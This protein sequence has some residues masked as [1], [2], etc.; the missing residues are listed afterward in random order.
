M[1][2]DETTKAIIASGSGLAA[3]G[4]SWK[5]LPAACRKLRAAIAAK[6]SVG[7]VKGLQKLQTVYSC[8]ERTEDYGSNR[9][10]IFGGHN[11]GGL[12]RANCKYNVSALHWFAPAIED[13]QISDYTELPVD[14]DYISMLLS[15][16]E[17]GFYRYRPSEHKETALL[18]QIYASSNV[19]DSIVI[20]IGFAEN[21]LLYASFCKTDGEEFT[22]SQVSHLRLIAGTIARAIA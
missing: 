14:A 18:R 16:I 4:A 3:I 8:L 1:S 6:R 10:I 9:S 12:P 20:F 13:N 22:D 2:Y 15:V 5:W 11:S 17:T 19:R 7:I 21:T